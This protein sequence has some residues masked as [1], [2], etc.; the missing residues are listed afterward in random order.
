[1]IAGDFMRKKSVIPRFFKSILYI[2]CEDVVAKYKKDFKIK[3]KELQILPT[4]NQKYF[5]LCSD[6]G[7]LYIALH[8]SSQKRYLRIDQILSTL[9]HELAHLCEKDH[10]DRWKKIHNK[11]LK[12]IKNNYL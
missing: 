10:N 8:G 7:K 3:F 1:M 5:G 6:D 2:I 11:F 12:Y 4:Q 9:S